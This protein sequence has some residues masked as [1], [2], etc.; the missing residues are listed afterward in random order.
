GIPVLAFR[1]LT[2]N[3]VFPVTSRRGRAAHLDVGGRRGEAI[4]RAARDQLGLSILEAK[5]VGLGGSGGST[6]PPLR[7]A[8]TSEAPE[9]YIFAKLYAKSHV[10]ADRSYKLGRAILYGALEGEGGVGR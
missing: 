7:V 6:P 8:A 3:E 2:P 5:T 4:V 10:R 1:V 9:R